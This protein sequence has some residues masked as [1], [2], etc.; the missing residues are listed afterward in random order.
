MSYFELSEF[1]FITSSEKEIRQ[2]V[3]L[4]N[5]GDIREPEI[6]SKLDPIKERNDYT[7]EE[8]IDIIQ[9]ITIATSDV[10]YERTDFQAPAGEALL[11]L[12]K[13]IN[14]EGSINLKLL[15]C[16]YKYLF[17]N[18][19][20]ENG[21]IQYHFS[22]ISN[23]EIYPDFLQ[24]TYYLNKKDKQLEI[25]V[26]IEGAYKYLLEYLKQQIII[27]KMNMDVYYVGQ[28][29]FSIITSKERGLLYDCETTEKSKWVYDSKFKIFIDQYFKKLFGEIERILHSLCN[30]WIFT[31]ALGTTNNKVVFPKRTPTR[32][33]SMSPKDW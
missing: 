27:I 1:S 5:N 6:N 12:A 25:A 18:E 33:E 11:H 21:N 28:A 3:I 20:D 29:N 16:S 15:Y 4:I 22:G 26:E 30:V 8:A 23:K 9:N 2:F 24:R 10:P 31:T 14:I 7:E 13:F 32:V 17:D 19:I